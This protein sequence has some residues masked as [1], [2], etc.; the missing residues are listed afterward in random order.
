MSSS[1]HFS[2]TPIYMCVFMF[3]NQMVKKKK[4][5]LMFTCIV[6]SV[7]SSPRFQK[8][9]RLQFF[10]LRHYCYFL[11]F[12]FVSLGFF[13]SFQKTHVILS[14][15]LTIPVIYGYQLLDFTNMKMP[16]IANPQF[17]SIFVFEQGRLQNLVHRVQ[18]PNPVLTVFSFG[19]TWVY[20]LL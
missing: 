10:F 9:R 14:I 7:N 19:V 8:K 15:F 5:E 1:F 3:L 6:C 18:E 13:F 12:Q 11:C 20:V 16:N 4:N 2:F 17:T